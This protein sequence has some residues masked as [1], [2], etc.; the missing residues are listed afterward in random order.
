MAI[1]GT[2]NVAGSNPRLSDETDSQRRRNECLSAVLTVQPAVQSAQPPT[3]AA[4][5]G[6]KKEPLAP[7]THARFGQSFSV[8]QTRRSE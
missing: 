5:G 4:G 3:T 7:R 6:R 2:R 8:S 1:L